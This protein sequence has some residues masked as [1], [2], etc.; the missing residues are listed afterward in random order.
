MLGI[1]DRMGAI[2]ILGFPRVAG[3]P[4]GGSFLGYS[5][6]GLTGQKG[7]ALSEFHFAATN[8]P[9]ARGKWSERTRFAI[10]GDR[11]PA[12]HPHPYRGQ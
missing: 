2:S 7:E 10:P 12:F 5:C 9:M 11:L 4:Q 3:G 6:P 1:G 8:R